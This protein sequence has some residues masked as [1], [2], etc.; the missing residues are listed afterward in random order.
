MR[1]R[2][3]RGPTEDDAEDKMGCPSSGHANG[4]R[5]YR[6]SCV[7]CSSRPISRVLCPRSLTGPR[8]A[9]IYLGRRLPAISSSLPGTCAERAAPPANPSR[10]WTSCP[11][12]W[13]CSWWGL[14][15]RPCHHVRRW[16]LTPPFHP[17]RAAWRGSLLFCGPFPSGCPDLG[18]PST[19]P[20]GARTFLAPV[21]GR[22]RLS[23]LSISVP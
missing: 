6:A 13:P 21:E 1:P 17:H 20:C 11:I 14:P 15:G 9:I 18:L 23:D 10:D 19:I 8:A 12:A 3:N 4:I 16:S 2:Y 5:W 22:D 7:S